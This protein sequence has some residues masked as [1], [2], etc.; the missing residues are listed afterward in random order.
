MLHLQPP[1]PFQE[2]LIDVE[3]NWP[4]HGFRFRIIFYALLMHLSLYTAHT[5]EVVYRRHQ[6]T[7]MI[8]KTFGLAKRCGLY[9][10]IPA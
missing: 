9:M 8:S 2:P 3:E 5:T 1:L 10:P 4:Y 7:V 6:P